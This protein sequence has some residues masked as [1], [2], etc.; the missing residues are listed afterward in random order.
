[1]Y[2]DREGRRGWKGGK[3]GK[4]LSKGRNGILDSYGVRDGEEGGSRG[5]GQ[6]AVREREDGRRVGRERR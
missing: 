1:M 2:S 3:Y 4:E 6:D 5:R